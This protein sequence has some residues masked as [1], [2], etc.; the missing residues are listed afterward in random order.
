MALL[1]RLRRSL[2]QDGASAPSSVAPASSARAALVRGL[3][4]AA[5]EWA[6]AILVEEAAGTATGLAAAP[7][8]A[9]ATVDDPDGPPPQWL[10]LVRQL[11]AERAA[12]GAATTPPF[13]DWDGPPAPA[14]DGAARVG[15]PPAATAAPSADGDAQ[16]AAAPPGRA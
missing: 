12:A 11:R 9:P 16:P 6:N 13:P 10:A 1:A 7:P 8:A 3:A 15:E 4:L 2:T 14:L 5:R